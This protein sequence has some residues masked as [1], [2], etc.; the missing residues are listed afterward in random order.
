[1]DKITQSG[2]QKLHAGIKE[3]ASEFSQT[4]LI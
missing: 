3:V 4:G 2:R 1:M